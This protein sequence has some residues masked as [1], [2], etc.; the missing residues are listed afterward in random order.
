MALAP[1]PSASIQID[2]EVEVEDGRF[3]ALVY[4]MI[5]RGHGSLVRWRD[6][7]DHD[8]ADEAITMSGMCI[9]PNSAR[10]RCYSREN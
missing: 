9:G 3:G 4:Q 1:F 8:G 5:L 2:V 10:R 6:R 7:G